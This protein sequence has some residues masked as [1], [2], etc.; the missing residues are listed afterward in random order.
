MNRQIAAI[1]NYNIKNSSNVY[2]CTRDCTKD[3]GRVTLVLL[4]AKLCERKINVLVFRCLTLTHCNQKVCIQWR[5]ATSTLFTATNGVNQ[6]G[7]LSPVYLT[8]I[9]TSYCLN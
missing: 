1:I 9:W 5:G 4:F 3:F 7:V 8:S 6:G 2:M